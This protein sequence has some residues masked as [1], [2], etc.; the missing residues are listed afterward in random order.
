MLNTIL[1][2]GKLRWLSVEARLGDVVLPACSQGC[3]AGPGAQPG[4]T[5]Q[6]WSGVGDHVRKQSDPG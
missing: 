4:K 2:P 5:G 6:I 3:R 1:G